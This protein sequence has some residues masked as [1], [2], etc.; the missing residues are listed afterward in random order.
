MKDAR[1]RC[2]KTIDIFVIFC[3]SVDTSNAEQAASCSK[4]V[5]QRAHIQCQMQKDCL[6]PW[7]ENVLLDGNL[8]TTGTCY[9]LAGLPNWKGEDIGGVHF[10]SELLL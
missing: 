2:D 9:R 4:K 3:T 1:Q 8:R 6:L 10:S 7:S 5:V